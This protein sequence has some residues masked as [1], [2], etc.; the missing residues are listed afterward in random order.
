MTCGLA[1]LETCCNPMVY[2]MGS[3][4]SGIRRLNL[5]QAINALG[6]V[7][8]MFITR[9]VV[10]DGI[11]PLSTETRMSLPVTQ[12]E[13]VKNHDLSVLI[14]PYTLISAIAVCCW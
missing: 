5:A 10:Q 4:A 7:I 8:G 12:F 13:I 11:S 2:C 3:E 9:N 1:L 6:A 14:Q